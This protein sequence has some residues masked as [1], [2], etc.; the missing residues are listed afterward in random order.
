MSACAALTLFL[1]GLIYL[2]EADQTLK[3]AALLIAGTLSL[4]WYVR[5]ALKKAN[6]LLNLRLVK[7]PL[8]QTAMLI[9]QFIPGIFTGV[10]LIAMLYLQNQLGMR[11]TMVG[12]M[13]IPWALA[14][15]A[16]ISLTG[17]KFNHT[18]PR[19]LFIAGCLV[20][21]AGIGLL[22]TIGDA[23]DVLTT[24]LAYTLM[25][26]GSS[27]CSS[28]AQSSAFIQ[29]ADSGLA[30]ASALWNIN[31]QLSFCFGVTII[32][33]LLNLMLN[34]GIPANEAF[35]LC[36]ILAACSIAIP[37]ACCLRI[38]NQN[39]ITLIQEKK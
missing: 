24:V 5:G 28:T 12:T 11:A 39:V 22:A 17:R 2:G 33:L 18:G 21:G 30:D 27:L 20:Q 31:R 25:G 6:P 38:S 32:S 13:M 8:L 9:Y 19:P 15:F 16:A 34:S 4:I 29:I 37:I 14:S 10:S 26:F 23:G 36:F 1:L 7:D 35:H 3:G